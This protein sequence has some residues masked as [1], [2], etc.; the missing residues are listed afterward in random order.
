MFCFSNWFSYCFLMRQISFPTI[1]VEF[2]F[3]RDGFCS[4]SAIS[5]IA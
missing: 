1:R 5:R 3:P 2:D 4:V